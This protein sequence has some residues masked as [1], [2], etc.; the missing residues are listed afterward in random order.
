MRS[1]SRFAST[2]AGFAVL[3]TIFIGLVLLAVGFGPDTLP[4]PVQSQYSDAVVSHWP[5]T[6]YFQQSLQGGALPLWRNLLMSGQQ[7]AANP[8]NKVWYPPQWLALL[9]PATVH[10]N[11]LIWL[12]LVLAGLGLRA[13]GRRLGIQP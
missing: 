9:L 2:N 6:I 13:F 12:H 1:I 3:L 11:V 8:L 10:L 7:F 4:F 5:N